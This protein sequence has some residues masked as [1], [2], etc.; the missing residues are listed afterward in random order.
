[1][2]RFRI[3]QI[4]MVLLFPYCDPGLQKQDVLLN[5]HLAYQQFLNLNLDDA[6]VAEEKHEKNSNYRQADRDLMNYLISRNQG[7][8]KSY[9]DI[10]RL[11]D[12]Y[13]PLLPLERFMSGIQ[14]M[15]RA[16]GNPSCEEENIALFYFKNLQKIANSLL[17]Y[18]DGVMAIRTWNNDKTELGEDIFYTN[19]VYNKVEVWNILCRF[20]IPDILM[21]IFIINSGWD[22]SALYEQKPNIS[23]ADKL[24]IQSLSKGVAE[25]HLHFNAGFD[26]EMLWIQA[27]HV[28]KWDG[29]RY[30]APESLEEVYL[31]QAAMF[32]CLAALFLQGSARRTH[33]FQKWIAQ[34]WDGT[35]EECIRDLYTGTF[36]ENGEKTVYRIPETF[37]DI[38][39]ENAA[40]EEADFLLASVY[41]GYVELKTSSEFLLLYNA[42]SYLKEQPWDTAFAK[43]FLQYLRIKNQFFYHMQQKFF[44][45]GLRHFQKYFGTAKAK[46][47]GASGWEG[48]TL[49]VFRSQ[50]KIA[51]LKK[52][53]VRITP[54]GYEEVQNCSDPESSREIITIQLKRQLFS[55]LFLYRR[56]IL[57]DILGVKEARRW[58]EEEKSHRLRKDFS[59]LDLFYELCGK[60]G[61]LEEDYRVPTL[62]IVFHFIKKESL[63][64]MSGYYCWRFL[65]EDKLNYT[66]HRLALRRKM[67]NAAKVIEEIRSEIP[68]LNTYIVGI[69]AASDENAMEP[70]MLSPVYNLIRSRETTRPVLAV[71]TQEGC[72]FELIQNLGFTYHVGEDFRH[73]LS[74]LRHIDEVIEEFHYKPGDRLGHGIALGIDIEKWISDN[75]ILP[76]PRQEYMD[77]LL[78]VWGLAVCEEFQLPVQLE[79]LEEE[80]LKNAE[81]I[82]HNTD[83]ITVRMLYKAYKAKFLTNHETKLKELLKEAGEARNRKKHAVH[84]RYSKQKCSL[85]P[86]QWTADRLLSTVYCPAFEE[87]YREIILVPIS[88]S[89][90]ALYQ[91]LQEIVL[92]K[93]EC[94][95]IYVETNPT[96][97]LTIGEF[98]DIREH[99]IFR[100]NTQSRSGRPHHVLVTVNSDDP[101]VFNTNVEN[102]LAYIYYAA[103][104]SGYSKEDILNWIDKIRQNGMNASFVQTVKSTAVLLEE[105]GR[106]LDRLDLE[107]G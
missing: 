81:A 62:G 12:F 30:A 75:E 15:K 64:N 79:R 68:E 14:E 99:P 69:D 67:V 61:G 53:E 87:K 95:G 22:E 104:Y 1:M 89:N 88:A 25:N 6:S 65:D 34:Q 2:N 63:D 38:W 39:V 92:E 17:T 41:D 84:C 33:L 96:S 76:M 106:I 86:T 80:I 54:Q 77:N 18:R 28:G 10:L 102:E 16:K 20:M 90:T 70:W 97:N 49:D 23:L 73:I 57:E 47:A 19:H 74:G 85:Y 98:S 59:Y 66:N 31:C 3:N 21:V 56:Y 11:C 9:D 43:C 107:L 58:L 60:Y 82:Y 7:R 29:I 24:L 103:E 40:L 51:S 72:R 45:P 35:L 44:V 5:K 91:T 27:V 101:A 83:G 48:L 42:C 13:F 52:L 50:A 4:M 105:L 26:Y 55:F 32:R 78:W 93:V 100:L 8:I 71:P 36:V 37:W 46:K 94:R